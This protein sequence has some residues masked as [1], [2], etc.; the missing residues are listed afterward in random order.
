LP[1]WPGGKS[2]AGEN[3]PQLLLTTIVRLLAGI[4]VRIALSFA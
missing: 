1:G 4:A 3:I 2:D